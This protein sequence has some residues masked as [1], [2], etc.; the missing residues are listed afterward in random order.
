MKPVEALQEKYFTDRSK[1]VL[2]CGSFM[3][4]F[5]SCVCNSFMRHI[6]F[7]PCGHLLGKG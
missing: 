3:G 4:F 6:L 1:T 2:F 5:L 7:V